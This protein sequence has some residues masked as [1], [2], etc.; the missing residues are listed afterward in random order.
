MDPCEPETVC[1]TPK[2]ELSLH[3]LIWRSEEN[4][5]M[6]EWVSECVDVCDDKKKTQYLKS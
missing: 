6:Y 5:S 2:M 1:D 4:M 3:G